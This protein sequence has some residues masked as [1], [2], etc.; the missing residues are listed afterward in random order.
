MLIDPA[1]GDVAGKL[2]GQ[3]GD[4]TALAFSRDGLQLAVAAGSPGTA[5]E[6]RIYKAAAGAFPPDRPPKP[7]PPTRTPFSILLFRPTARRWP[8]AATTGSSSCGT[9][10]PAS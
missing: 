10:K 2:P 1:T 7:S 5:G 9:R 8:P 6:V 3:A 4:V